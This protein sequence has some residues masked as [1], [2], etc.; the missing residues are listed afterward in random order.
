MQ[1]A[2]DERHLK[3]VD[4]LNC[5]FQF[6]CLSR[7]QWRVSVILLQTNALKLK[8]KFHLVNFHF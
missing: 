6:Q 1:I 4:R 7:H 3:V 8:W 2:L 5:E